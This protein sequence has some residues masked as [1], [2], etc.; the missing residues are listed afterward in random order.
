MGVIV[1][2]LVS[3]L[4]LA[5]DCNLNLPSAHWRP[6]DERA[7]PSRICALHQN[8]VALASGLYLDA[9]KYDPPIFDL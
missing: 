3:V 7:W 5:S 4:R 2:S 9:A 6:Q 8:C 1:L